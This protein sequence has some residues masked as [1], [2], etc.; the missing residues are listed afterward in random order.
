MSSPRHLI[1]VLTY[2][3]AS[4]AARTLR[5][6]SKQE[7]APFELLVVDNT[8]DDSLA[9]ALR[10]EFPP[11]EVVRNPSNLGYAGGHNVALDLARARDAESVLLCNH[12]IEVGPRFLADMLAA[13]SSSED[14]GLV[15]AVEMDA[16]GKRVRAA[17]G[18]GLRGLRF[19][20]HWGT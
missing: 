6:L 5:C 20:A 12:D 8:P 3:D 15:G 13:A 9:A 17:G 11:L 4:R 2:G 18:S 1:S 7:G 10:A 16:D 14:V 19:Q